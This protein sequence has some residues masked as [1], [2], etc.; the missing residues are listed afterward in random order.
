MTKLVMMCQCRLYSMH[1]LSR[2]TAY[3][4]TY[5]HTSIVM[6]LINTSLFMFIDT[7]SGCPFPSVP[8]RE[9]YPAFS[10]ITRLINY[11]RNPADWKQVDK[12]G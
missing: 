3:L 7:A 1:T 9:Q 11:Y 10:T 6:S 5:L 8:R 2:P 12:G 4:H